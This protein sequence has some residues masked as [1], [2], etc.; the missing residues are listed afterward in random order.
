M[1]KVRVGWRPGVL[2]QSTKC[3]CKSTVHE[4]HSKSCSS[5]HRNDQKAKPPYCWAVCAK[6]LQSCPTLG[7]PMDCSP[8]GSS[9]HGDSPGKN[10][11]VGC[12]AFFQGI[13]PTQGSDRSLLNLLNWWAGS[14]PLVPPWKPVLLIRRFECLDKIPKQPQHSL[15]PKFKPFTLFSSLR[16]VRKW[17]K[18]CLKSEETRSWG[19][20][21]KPFP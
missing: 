15:K 8:P 16:E 14:W 17:L 4:G 19:W 12:R 18:K 6:S 7:N 21:K 13:F 9:V 20:R 10:T 2:S 11:E 3:E 1:L 5:E